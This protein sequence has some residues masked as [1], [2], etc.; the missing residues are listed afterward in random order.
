MTITLIAP[1]TDRRAKYVIIYNMDAWPVRSLK[2]RGWYHAPVLYSRLATEAEK[3]EAAQSSRYLAYRYKNFQKLAE[4][5]AKYGVD[6]YT[7]L[8]NF[9]E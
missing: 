3:E 5:E 4:D 1:K 2:H 8:P 6:I 9:K 7:L